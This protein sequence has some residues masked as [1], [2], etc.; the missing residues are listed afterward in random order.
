MLARSL[1][2]E[3]VAVISALAK[4]TRDLQ[5]RNSEIESIKLEIQ[6]GL[7][8]KLTIGDDDIV[9][10]L[11][12]N[13]EI[14]DPRRIYVPEASRITSSIVMY[15]SDSRSQQDLRLAISTVFPCLNF[16]S[17]FTSI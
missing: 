4:E 17:I 9:Y 8:P 5:P 3:K 7:H 1:L 13:I 14:G 16:F 2:D 6:K 10:Y 11:D 15:A 12:K